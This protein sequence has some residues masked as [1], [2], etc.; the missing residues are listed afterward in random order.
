MKELTGQLI[1]QICRETQRRKGAKDRREQRALGCLGASRSH[2]P[3]LADNEL[4]PH[5]G[6]SPPRER[7]NRWPGTGGTAGKS[8]KLSL[9]LGAVF[10]L[11]HACRW[12]EHLWR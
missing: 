4:G 8:W 11:Y 12:P 2:E 7:G 9:F 5:A 6:P 3:S 10:F 1:G